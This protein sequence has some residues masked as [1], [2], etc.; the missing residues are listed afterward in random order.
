[1]V[2]YLAEVFTGA[3]SQGLY[4]TLQAAKQAIEA[5]AAAMEVPNIED[6]VWVDNYGGGFGWAP[7]D[8]DQSKLLWGQCTAGNGI[9]EGCTIT[10]LDLD[11]PLP[12]V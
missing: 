9:M 5:H 7:K 2:M 6:M 10:V 11:E 12:F 1:M 4:S 3:S 8:W